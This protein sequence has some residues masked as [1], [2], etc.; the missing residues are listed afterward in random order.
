MKGWIIVAFLVAVSM[1]AEAGTSPAPSLRAENL[2]ADVNARGARAV[3]ATLRSD[4]S[5]WDQVMTNIGHG[6]RQ[7]LEVAAALRPGTDAGASEALDEA[8]FLALRSAP[9]RVLQM[10]K[11][12]TFDTTI[13]CSSN[14]GTDYSGAQSRRFIKDRMKVLKGVSDANTLA[15]RDQCL[16][17]LRTALADFD[18]SKDSLKD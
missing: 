10:L 17:G 16:A 18:N 1:V 3:V 9:T 14:I 2:L 11:N 4:T 15:V 8:V 7:W 6:S 13:V 5:L 12:G